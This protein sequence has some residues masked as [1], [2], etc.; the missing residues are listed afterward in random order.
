M[1]AAPR[2]S[3]WR[4]LGRSFLAGAVVDLSFGL[5]ILFAADR[6][7]PVM[8]LTLPS[9][10]VYVDLNGLLLCGLGGIYLLVWRRPREL[11]GVAAV[12]T[13]LRWGGCALFVAE[14]AAG[15]AEPVFLGLAALDGGLALAHLVLLRRAAGGLW[16]ALAGEGA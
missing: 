12:A 2:E 9:P 10:A 1:S 7:A 11:A 6:L 3:A 5:A 16:R 8:R 13:L 15:R 14:V 4:W